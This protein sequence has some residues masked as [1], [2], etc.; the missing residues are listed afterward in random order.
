MRGRR[1]FVGHHQ[2]GGLL[3]GFAVGRRGEQGERLRRGDALIE[4]PDDGGEAFLE[5]IPG[6][7]THLRVDAIAVDIG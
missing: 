7:D 5:P 4:E 1:T 6:A 2:R 3:Q